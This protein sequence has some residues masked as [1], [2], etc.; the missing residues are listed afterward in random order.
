MHRSKRVLIITK[1][2]TN[3][4]SLV[5]DPPPPSVDDI[6]GFGVT[7]WLCHYV[8]RNMSFYRWWL[9]NLPLLI[10]LDLH[11]F[12][13]AQERSRDHNSFYCWKVWRICDISFVHIQRLW[14]RYADNTGVFNKRTTFYTKC[15]KNWHYR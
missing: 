11:W 3:V 10:S 5:T 14:T 2:K 8:I 6:I 15:H 13:W 7:L 9:C 4:I 1:I 12:N